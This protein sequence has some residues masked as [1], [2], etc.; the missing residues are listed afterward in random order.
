[1]LGNPV[2]DE[3]DPEYDLISKKYDITITPSIYCW[4]GNSKFYTDFDYQHHSKILNVLC[5]EKFIVFHDILGNVF[6]CNTFQK[7][8]YTVYNTGIISKYSPNFAL[9]PSLPL[10]ALSDD[11]RKN[12]I[13]YNFETRRKITINI[14]Y[15]VAESINYQSIDW[16]N[17][18]LF[19]KSLYFQ[20]YNCYRF[21][22]DKLIKIDAP[23]YEYK[24]L[25]NT[26]RIKIEK[27]Y[28]GLMVY[29]KFKSY[30]LMDV[31]EK[32]KFDYSDKIFVYINYNQLTILILN[33]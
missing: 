19:V 28:D 27:E 13:I 21:E 25:V 10:L 20:K 17:G 11:T 4:L 33:K 5:N 15:V 32:C 18:N 16:Q 24:S 3:W 31:G 22:N 23:K 26:N 2:V 9:H 30:K 6:V 1:V 14:N 12:I 8:V 7:C 29:N